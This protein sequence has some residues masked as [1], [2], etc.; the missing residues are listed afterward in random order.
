MIAR[1]T[2]KNTQFFVNNILK[3]FSFGNFVVEKGVVL[4]YVL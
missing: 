2:E 3:N 4:R 1:E